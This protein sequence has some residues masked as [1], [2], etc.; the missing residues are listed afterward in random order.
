MRFF[1]EF[2]VP[3]CRQYFQSFAGGPR[4]GAYELL[5]WF[6]PRAGGKAPDRAWANR[7][8]EGHTPAR[9][10]DDL[11]EG[12]WNRLGEPCDLEALEL[13]VKDE[14]QAFLDCVDAGRAG[15][16]ALLKNW[17]AGVAP[18]SRFEEDAR[19]ALE[20]IRRQDPQPSLWRE[21][22]LSFLT[23]G[24]DAHEALDRALREDG[25]Q[26]ST[27]PFWNALGRIAALVDEYGAEG[28]LECVV[29]CMEDAFNLCM[30]ASFMGDEGGYELYA[31]SQR[32]GTMVQR[33]GSEAATPTTGGIQLAPVTFPDKGDA[34]QAV[35]DRDK[36]PYEQLDAASP[37]TSA[38][39]CM[40][41]DPYVGIRLGR[42]ETWIRE[43][44]YLPVLF[45]MRATTVSNR[46][47]Q[48]M[49]NADRW[50]VQDG[51][52]Y[53]GKS[54]NGTLVVRADGSGDVFR[55]GG[56][57]VELRDGDYLCLSPVPEHG[58][59]VPPSRGPVRCFLVTIVRQDPDQLRNQP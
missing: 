52:A 19:A 54:T 7:V 35:L 17:P 5:G 12:I 21:L 34:P 47:A 31:C 36:I 40:T 6:I 3:F 56:A 23:D 45:D 53:G 15:R 22:K 28:D 43:D 29:E 55:K 18:K 41:D 9:V 51:D 46:H 39:T 49:R 27:T 25:W 44:G 4:I 33:H 14:A 30:V 8:Y 24:P 48:I 58:R 10:R 20:K 13:Y 59:H 16:D 26:G 32:R 42:D 2:A 1:R 37:G 50:L 38:I 57:P 11:V